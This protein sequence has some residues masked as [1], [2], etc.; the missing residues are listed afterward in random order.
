[1]RVNF[2]LYLLQH[3]HSS[4]ATPAHHRVLLHQRTLLLCYCIKINGHRENKHAALQIDAPRM[5]P[6]HALGSPARSPTDCRIT[7]HH[8]TVRP[9]LWSMHSCSP[10]SPFHFLNSH[11]RERKTCIP[12]ELLSSFFTLLNRTNRKFPS[13]RTCTYQRATNRLL[14]DNNNNIEVYSEHSAWVLL[15]TRNCYKSNVRKQKA[16][17]RVYVV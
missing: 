3:C 11:S 8:T 13:L 1:M 14:L 5:K 9:L 17:G 12:H 2:L 10:L 6:I 15:P 4:Y 16:Y 7:T